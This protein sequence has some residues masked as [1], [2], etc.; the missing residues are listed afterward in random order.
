MFQRA[1]G[2]AWSCAACLLSLAGLAC[3]A[4]LPV[5]PPL[6][7]R[8]VDLTETLDAPPFRVLT[9]TDTGVEPESAAG[10]FADLDGDGRTEVVLS[11]G[12][13]DVPRTAV[14]Y[15]YD[16]ASRRLVAHPTV[17][18]P[19]GVPVRAAADLDGDGIVDLLAPGSGVRVCWG[20]GAGAF[21]AQRILASGD[22]ARAI[23]FDQL[24]LADVDA[25]GWLDVLA[26]DGSCCV[27]CTPAHPL[28]RT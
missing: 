10:A 22:A 11:F 20:L 16:A 25:D 21:D 3:E 9:T 14:A 2:L 6:E 23:Y 18:L 8:F 13:W 5:A 19:A 17:A 12:S 4:P 24:A 28:L 1:R 7:G 15:D 26:G 27:G